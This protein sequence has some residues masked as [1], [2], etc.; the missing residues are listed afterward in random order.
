MSLFL[1]YQVYNHVDLN[2][3]SFEEHLMGLFNQK[4]KLSL[5]LYKFISYVNRK[6]IL[7]NDG[8]QKLMVPIEFHS[9][10]LRY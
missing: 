8:N 9:I 7:K 6:Y 10:S 5:N 1:T 2:N 3:I 4:Y